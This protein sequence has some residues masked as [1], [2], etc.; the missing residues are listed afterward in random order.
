MKKR[1][2]L[3]LVIAVRFVGLRSRTIAA[4]TLIPFSG[5]VAGPPGSTVG[6]GYTITNNT[7]LWI[8]AE[9]VSSDAFLN[10]TPT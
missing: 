1:W 3:L 9:A 2:F 5:G 7:A 10:G 4:L 6:W 8:R